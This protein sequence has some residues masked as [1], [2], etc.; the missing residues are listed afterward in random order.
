MIRLRYQLLPYTYALFQEASRSGLPVMRPLLLEYPRDEATY[1]L[2][3]EFL[4]G[5]DLLVAPVVTKGVKTR[6]VYLPEGKWYDWKTGQAASGPGWIEVPTPL[7][8]LPLF[9][10][11]G[12]IIP[13]APVMMHTGAK[14]WDP[15]TW[16]IYPGESELSF[17][18]YE[19]DG[20]SFAYE[21]GQWRRTTLLVRP[22][23]GSLLVEL[24]P[25]Q[26]LY[27]PPAR[28]FRLELYDLPEVASVLRRAPG[29]PLEWVY[30]PMTR[31]LIVQMADPGQAE[32]L[33][34]EYK[35]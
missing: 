19:D 13:L 17:A 11:A 24:S 15:I 7:G 6:K 5:R 23:A 27:S 25:P 8:A 22:G 20:Q 16:R 12:A 18:L 21:K 10:R 1:S 4:W 14:P 2:A 9:V 32:T 29:T 34:I 31:A 28:S 33:T 35:K 30:D 3:D 26:G